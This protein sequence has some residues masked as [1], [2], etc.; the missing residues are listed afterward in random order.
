MPLYDHFQKPLKSISQW[1]SFHF[2]WLNSLARDINP[3]LPKHFFAEPNAKFEIEID[4]ATL[5]RMRD[6]GANGYYGEWQSNWTP[7]PPVANV[8]FAI[9]NDELE[10]LV[11]GEES[12]GIRIVA[13]LELVS[14]ANKDRPESRDAFTTKCQ[15]YLQRGIGLIIIDITTKHHF[16]LHNELMARI[17]S[18][19]EMIDG[20][21]YA[22][23]YRPTGKKGLGNL[24]LW[25]QTLTIGEPLP[26]MPLWLLGGIC[27]PVRL[28]ETYDLTLRDLKV[29]ER[30]S[31]MNP[32]KPSKT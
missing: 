18:S 7:P 13:A 30:L 8:P 26:T 17:G 29:P 22:V 2:A 6:T 1:N 20:H 9:D 16:N 15:G 11:Y 32:P 10:V 3:Q 12:E 25:P 4:M 21:I 28:E 14:P 27:I 19:S 23:A 5:E 24:A 31:L